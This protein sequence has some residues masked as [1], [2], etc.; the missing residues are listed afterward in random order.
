MYALRRIQWSN[1]LFRQLMYR[2]VA[3]GEILAEPSLYR[4]GPEDTSALLLAREL[5]E[6]LLT[7]DRQ[8]RKQDETETQVTAGH[9]LYPAFKNASN[10]CSRRAGS[11]R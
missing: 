10:R 11:G 6:I 8:L 7:G 9:L 5:G 1:Y 2:T 4:L 3:E